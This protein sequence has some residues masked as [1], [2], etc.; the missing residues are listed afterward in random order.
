MNNSRNIWCYVGLSDIILRDIV[1]WARYVE[2]PFGSLWSAE[3]SPRNFVVL[4]LWSFEAFEGHP[5]VHAAEHVGFA[6][7]RLFANST[8]S[9]LISIRDQIIK[10]SMYHLLHPVCCSGARILRLE[11]WKHVILGVTDLFQHVKLYTF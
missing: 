11:C 2:Y 5:V 6:Y 10:T 3:N 7:R 8:S 4:L 1:V 9:P